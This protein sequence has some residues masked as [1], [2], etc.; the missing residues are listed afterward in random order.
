M[1]GCAC[2]AGRCAASPARLPDCA[3]CGP[4][5]G[6]SRS[7]PRWPLRSGLRRPR[8][9]APLPSGFVDEVVQA[10]L[11]QPSSFAFLPDGR[12]LVVEQETKRIRLLVGGGFGATDPLHTIVPCA[13]A[14][15]RSPQRSRAK[16]QSF[17]IFSRAAATPRVAL[18]VSKTRGARAT[19]R[20]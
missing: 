2:N 16:A 1:V 4:A 18:R 19:T 7:A 9:T 10:E 8:R 11:P 17:R 13:A 3:S 12:I 14:P 20:A 6:G 15:A 5:V